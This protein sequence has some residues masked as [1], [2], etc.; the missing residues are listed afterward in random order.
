MKNVALLPDK[1]NDTSLLRWIDVNFFCCVIEIAH[2]FILNF[3]A[4]MTE[5][6]YVSLESS[7]WAVLSFRSKI[8]DEDLLDDFRIERWLQVSLSSI[9]WHILVFC[10]RV[11]FSLNDFHHS[12]SAFINCTCKFDFF[13][14]QE[15]SK[16]HLFKLICWSWDSRLTSK[17]I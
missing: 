1:H 4:A 12:S 6:K 14:K 13:S 11:R 15:K 8:S 3:K 17:C 16:T 10:D 2:K 9:C 7:A 5:I